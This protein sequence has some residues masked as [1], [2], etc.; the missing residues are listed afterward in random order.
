MSLIKVMIAVM[1]LTRHERET[2]S[3]EN[4]TYKCPHE[5]CD[6]ASNQISN[7][8][9]HMRTHS[10]EKPYKCCHEGCGFASNQSG[11][12]NTHMRTHTGEKPYKCSHEGCDFA[13]NQFN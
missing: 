12:L 7:L 9:T 3:G 8:T 4:L 11:Q 6:Y 5:G 1:I 10:G 2:H 13:S